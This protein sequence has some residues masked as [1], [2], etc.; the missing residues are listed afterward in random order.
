MT[1]K[2]WGFIFAR[3]GS[4]GLPGKNIR[5]LDGVPLLGYAVR[6]AHDSGCVERVIVSTDDPAIAEAAR[7]CGAE[8]PFLRPAELAR[9][10]SPEWLAWRHAVDALDYFD[11]FV[12]LPATAPLRIGADVKACVETYLRGDCDMVVTVRA[13]ERHPSFNMVR[14]DE[15]GYASLLMPLGDVAR[16]QD[17]P[18]AFDM[19]TVA[20]VTSPR[21]IRE[22]SG[23]FQGRVRV[24]EVPAERAVDIDTELDFAFA[25]FLMRR[26]NQGKKP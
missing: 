23:L 21:F 20:Y 11:V 10:D 18:A 19:T 22:H 24:V 5:P 7:A 9:D 12:S 13:A 1:P 17:A 26:R 25:E 6:A 16:R 14:L 3:G 2:I 4:K 8:V 15:D